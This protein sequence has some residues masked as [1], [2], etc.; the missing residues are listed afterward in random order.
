MPRGP[1]RPEPAVPKTPDQP[2][3]MAKEGEYR[4]RGVKKA[5]AKAKTNKTRQ[6]KGK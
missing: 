2:Q 5:T 1:E 4:A 6:W 3:R